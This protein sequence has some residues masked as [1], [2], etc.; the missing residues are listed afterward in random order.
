MTSA[1]ADGFMFDRAAETMARAELEALQG[2]RLK[3]MLARTYAKVPHVRAKFDA[4]GVTPDHFKSLADLARF[5]FSAKADLRDNFPFGLFAVPREQVLRLHASSGTTGRPTVVGYTKADLDL[6]ADLMARSLACMGAKPG[7]VFHNAYG[8]GLFTGGLGF[9][10]GA[11]RL[12]CTTVPVSGGATERQVALLQDFGARFIGATPSYALNI[13]EVAD[14][15]GVDLHKLPLRY[16]AFGAEPW[17]EAMRRDIEARFDIKAMD[18]Y[19]L[20]EIIGPG[21]ASE[22]HQAQ[23]GLHIWEDHFLCEVIDPDTTQVLPPG[24]AGELVL[25]TLTKEALPMIRYRTRDITRLS[26]E[27]C[28]CGR[29]HRRMLRVTGRSDDMLIIR[30]VNVYPSQVE[31]HLVGFPGLAP[32][33]QIV[34]TREG[35]MDAMTVEVELT[36]PA[37]ADELFLGRMAAEV[38]DHLKAMVGVTCEVVLKAPGEVPRSQGKA[39]RVKDLRQARKP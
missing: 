22:C 16:G 12:G 6:W 24:E 31:A 15:M 14:G 33:Y 20:S 36:T 39:V 32:H 1:T 30:G 3:E 25:T 7:D 8:Y 11:E 37:P 9:H 4:A 35:P 23:S 26:D 21:V 38:H 28:V 17:S 13:A 5:P 19:G 10:Y 18:T 29:T 27:P 2:K 34:L